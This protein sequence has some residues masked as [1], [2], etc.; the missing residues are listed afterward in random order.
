MAAASD[1]MSVGVFL[2]TALP[3][4]VYSS[5]DLV[6]R[7]LPIFLP[8]WGL[9]GPRRC[10][11][12]LFALAK[13]WRNKF[14]PLERLDERGACTQPRLVRCPYKSTGADQSPTGRF[15]EEPCQSPISVR[16][17]RSPVGTYEAARTS[18]TFTQR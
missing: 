17:F 4:W 1:R 16:G 10:A 14:E 13:R 7:G 11:A 2:P 6:L 18:G 9:R 3:M 12:L 8:S 15:G 5:V